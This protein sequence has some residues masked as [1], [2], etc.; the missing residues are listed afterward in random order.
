MREGAVTETEVPTLD[1]L[2]QEFNRSDDARF[3]LPRDDLALLRRF[4]R[5]CGPNTTAST[6]PS[7][8]D[9]SASSRSSIIL[10]HTPASSLL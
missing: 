6:V 7:H 2:W 5:W 4:V 10:D 3:E 9:L 8:R 1:R